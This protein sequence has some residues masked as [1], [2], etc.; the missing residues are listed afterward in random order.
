MLF[1]Q[2]PASIGRPSSEVAQRTRLGAILAIIVAL[3]YYGF[4]LAG[5]FAPLSLAQPAIGHVPWSFV[6]GAGLLI[7]AIALTGLYVLLA[8]AADRRTSGV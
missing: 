3:A 4:L 6:L 7:G 5:A 1:P 2:T 8:N